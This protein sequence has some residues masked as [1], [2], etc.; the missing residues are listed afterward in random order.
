[1]GVEVFDLMR[2]S[3]VHTAMSI[4]RQSDQISPLPQYSTGEQ[5]SLGKKVERKVCSRTK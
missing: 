4:A 3:N 2:P 1:M 5:D